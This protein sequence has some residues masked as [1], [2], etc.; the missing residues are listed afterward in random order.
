MHFAIPLLPL[1]ALALPALTSPV[2][3]RLSP[4][5][6]VSMRD[7]ARSASSAAAAASASATATASID[8]SKLSPSERVS[9]RNAQRLA[10]STSSATAAP[11][12]MP[13][14]TVFTG[15]YF[16]SDRVEHV[17]YLS[18]QFRDRSVEGLSLEQLRQIYGGLDAFGQVSDWQ[19]RAAVPYEGEVVCPGM[20]KY[21]TR[22]DNRR[23][24]V[25]VSE[26]FL[27][28]HSLTLPQLCGRGLFLTHPTTGA[29]RV[30]TIRGSC[31][32]GH[33]AGEGVAL[34]RFTRQKSGAGWREDEVAEGTEV[35]F[36]IPSLARL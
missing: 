4:A 23:E 19:F 11:T 31:A 2:P 12:S 34:S 21:D 28:A 24:W 13:K 14:Q 32:S 20:D 35:Q 10:T 5:E 25:T 1:L 29:R 18:G 33:C 27:A 16:F 15:P 17:S 26:D 3:E 36:E 9:L 8:W 22:D 6:R 7:A 30:L